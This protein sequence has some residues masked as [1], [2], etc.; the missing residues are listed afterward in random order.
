VNRRDLAIVGALLL[1]GFVLLG[2]RGAAECPAGTG[3]STPRGI[4]W[5]LPWE[6]PAAC[7]E[8]GAD[9]PGPIN[10][11]WFRLPPGHLLDEIEPLAT[12]WR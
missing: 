2:F 9:S 4:A 12:R 7:P 5:H 8:P 10:Q 11:P 1:V 3:T 6:T